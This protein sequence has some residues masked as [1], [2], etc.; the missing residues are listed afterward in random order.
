MQKKIICSTSKFTIISYV[1][2]Q[3][4][5]TK[6]RQMHSKGYI[7][8]K[9]TSFFLCQRS[10]QFESLK[11]HPKVTLIRSDHRSDVLCLINPMSLNSFLNS[12]D[13]FCNWDNFSRLR[14]AIQLTLWLC[15]FMC[16]MSASSFRSPERNKLRGASPEL[17]RS[18]LS[19]KIC[20][21]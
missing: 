4:I 2:Q 3:I 8:G 13:L 14:F 21:P 18:K 5:M 15:G 10:S 11:D 16:S 20:L 19:L 9:Q 7:Q 17:N 12:V 1:K 6:F